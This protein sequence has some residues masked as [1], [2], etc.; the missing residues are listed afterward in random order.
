MN[1]NDPKPPIPRM[2]LKNF[3][4]RGDLAPSESESWR[5]FGLALEDARKTFDAIPGGFWWRQ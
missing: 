2:P 5:S 4:Y 1:E 3:K